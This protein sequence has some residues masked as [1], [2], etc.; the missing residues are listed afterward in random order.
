LIITY[1]LL[2]NLVIVVVL[3]LLIQVM[4]AFSR[5][6]ILNTVGRIKTVINLNKNKTPFILVTCISAIVI[7]HDP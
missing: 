3:I 4:Q 2:F 5:S 1:E 6:L 7:Y